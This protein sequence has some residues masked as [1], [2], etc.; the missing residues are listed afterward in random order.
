MDVTLPSSPLAASL[1]TTASSPAPPYTAVV[2][3]AGFGTRLRPLTNALPKEM[4]PVGRSVALEHIVAEMRAAGVRRVVFVLSSAKEALVRSRFGDS[5]PDSGMDFAYVVQPEMRGL[6]EAVLRTESL[7]EASGPFLVALGDAVFEEPHTGGLVRRLTD[8]AAM[9]GAGIGLAVQRVPPE[10]IS[11]YG[12]VK[13]LAD[14]AASAAGAAYLPIADIVEKPAPEE[15]P[16][17]LAAAARYI[18]TAEVF[19][20]LRRTPP[21]RNGEI[22]LTDALRIL[23][24]A[25]RGGVAVPLAPGEVR[26]DLGSLDSYFKAFA[27]FALADPEVGPGLG[28]F[29]RERL[30]RGAGVSM[31][32][33]GVIE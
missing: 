9:T 16:S 30:E 20:V 3:A 24:A 33:E 1:A 31:G 12:V 15:A 18:V 2:P 26:H 29:L 5:D 25:G 6:G 7:V 21:A 8:A 22:Q 28:S 10:R 17:D 32:K 4:L 11:R 14:S 13:P 19:D 23:L 27:A